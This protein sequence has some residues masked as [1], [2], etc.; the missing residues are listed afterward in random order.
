MVGTFHMSGGNF[1]S[2]GKF[3]VMVWQD[4]TFTTVHTEQWTWQ[5]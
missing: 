5:Y 1:H 2:G 4:A 3:T